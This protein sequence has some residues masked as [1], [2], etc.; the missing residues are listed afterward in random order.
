MSLLPMVLD[1]IIY[2]AQ[3][4]RKSSKSEKGVLMAR[5]MVLQ[6]EPSIL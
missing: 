6:I 3:N 5:G 2:K 4:M 1:N